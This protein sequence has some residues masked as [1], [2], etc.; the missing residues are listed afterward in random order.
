MERPAPQDRGLRWLAL[1]AVAYLIGQLLGSP[2]PQQNDLGQA[3]QAEQTLQHLGVTAPTTEAVLIQERSPG[4]TS[5]TDPA[6]RQAV[7]Q[8]AASLSRLPGAAAGISSPLRPGGQAHRP[9]R[10]PGRRHDT[11]R[12]PLLVPTRPRPTALDTPENRR[13]AGTL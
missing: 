11:A 6:M 2:S 12:R 13:P 8:V 7:S 9:Q 3:G 4:Q 5:A 10:P 1:V